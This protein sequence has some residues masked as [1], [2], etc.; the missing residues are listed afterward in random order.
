MG[1]YMAGL[2]GT[3]RHMV[4]GLGVHGLEWRGCTAQPDPTTPWSH[5]Q[6]RETAVTPSLFPPSK[7]PTPLQIQGIY[8]RV[9]FCHISPTR[10]LKISP[11]GGRGGGMGLIQPGPPLPDTRGTAGARPFP[12]GPPNP[13]PR[14]EPSPAPTLLCGRASSAFTPSHPSLATAPELPPRDPSWGPPLAG[15]PRGQ[16]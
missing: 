8:L 9:T 1:W 5:S 3:V 14:A 12:A 6:A 2:G 16:C 10:A 7:A 11:G 15:S 4:D 13:A